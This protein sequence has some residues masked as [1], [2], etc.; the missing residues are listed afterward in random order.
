[1]NPINPVSHVLA[2]V[3]AGAHTLATSLGLAPGSAGAWLAALALL[4]VAV[5]GVT[6]P[7][8]VRGVRDSHARAH[9]RPQLLALQAR[10]A[11]RLDAEGLRRLR[12]ER[13]AVHAEHGVAS[14][15][16]AP[17]LLQLPLLLA[18]YRVV[19]QVTAG[20]PLGALD[21]GLV[22][23]A[24]SASVLG[25]HLSSRLGQ[26]PSHPQGLVLLA[27]VALGSALLS[28]ATSRW[29]TVP[30]TDP[31][32][33]PELL[34]AAQRW[35]PAAGAVGVLA[36]AWVVPAGLVAYWFLSNLW[37]FAQQGLVWRF[38]PTPGSPAAQRRAAR[39]GEQRTA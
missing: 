24:A 29:F 7:L 19:S 10:Y 20:H 2:A 6:V 34:V 30:M 12:A 21:A 14:W 39:R 37:T 27:A 25:V 13:K 28:W 5:R 38:A 11:G 22:A 1:M 26:L 18:L 4:V 36:A 23:S 33:Q 3:L 9:A 32:G 15:G 16:L 8:V 35:L 31:T 17:A